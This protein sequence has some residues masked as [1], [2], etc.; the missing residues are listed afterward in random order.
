VRLSKGISALEIKACWET[1]ILCACVVEKLVCWWLELLVLVDGE[2]WCSDAVEIGYDS[3]V[4][5]ILM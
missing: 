3:V 1:R 5:S 4:M 2:G